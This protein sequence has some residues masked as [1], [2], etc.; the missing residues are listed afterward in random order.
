M[1]RIGRSQLV[2]G[3]VPLL[4]DID[5]KLNAVSVADV[6]RVID[7]V[8]TTPRVVAAVGPFREDDFS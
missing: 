8:L 4:E 2:H 6:R 5:D 1:S 3:S 7:R